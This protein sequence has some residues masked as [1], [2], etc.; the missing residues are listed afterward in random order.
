LNGGSVYSNLGGSAWL[1][2]GAT[3][4]QVGLTGPEYTSST[5][6]KVTGAI[7]LNEA[8][9]VIGWSERY[10][11]FTVSGQGVWLYNGTTTIP[12]GLT[13]PEY[14]GSDGYHYS[15]AYLLNEGGQIAGYTQFFNGVDRYPVGQDAWF[16]DPTLHQTIRLRLSQHSDGYAN[17]SVS[18]LGEDGLVLGT[19]NL[20]DALDHFLGNRIFSFTLADG[21]HDLGAMVDGGLSAHGWDYLASFVRANGRGQIL[22]N[23]KLTSQTSGQI[24]YL[25]TPISVPEPD[26][27]VL[28]ILCLLSHTPLHRRKNP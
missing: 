10:V 19:Y 2:D 11:G 3:T 24:P 1:Y 23:G 28:A 26:A 22:G 6:K 15:Q 17:S 16:Y 18:Y 27:G 4:I 12:I 5:G 9:Q 20:Y 7:K 8:G 14:T 13:E 21:L 25:L